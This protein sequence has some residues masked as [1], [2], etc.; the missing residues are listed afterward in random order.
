MSV[1]AQVFNRSIFHCVLLS[2]PLVIPR[3]T[4]IHPEVLEQGRKVSSRFR[5]KNQVVELLNLVAFLQQGTEPVCKVGAL[6]EEG[7]L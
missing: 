5:E 4:H 6:T 3:E 7:F 2:E 1:E